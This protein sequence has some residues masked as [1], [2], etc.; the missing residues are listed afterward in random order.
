MI[1]ALFSYNST[2]NY[3]YTERKKLGCSCDWDSWVADYIVFSI[4]A[5]FY[6]TSRW[7]F[8]L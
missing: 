3:F 4:L 5:A 7:Y 2:I 6:D 8:I 1:V